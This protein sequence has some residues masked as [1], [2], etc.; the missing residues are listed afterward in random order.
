VSTRTALSAACAALCIVGCSDDGSDSPGPARTD[1][2]LVA[3]NGC[4]GLAEVIRENAIA[5]MN[6]SLDRAM[7]NYLNGGGCWE[8]DAAA[9]GDDGGDGDGSE[10]PGDVSETN[11]Q[12]AGVDEAD[13]VKTDGQYLYVTANGAL[14]ILAA[15]PAAATREVAKV[16]LEGDARKLFVLG[17]RALVYVSSAE[18]PYPC[19][20]GYDCDFGGDGTS[21]RLVVLDISDREKPV[22]LRELSL[23]GSLIAARRIGSAVHT[24]VSDGALTFEGLS[25]HPDD[26]DWCAESPS[27]L[28]VRARF[29]ELRK[30]NEQLIRA[31]DVLGRLPQVKDSLDGSSSLLASCQGFYATAVRQ[32]ASFTTLVSLDMSADAAPTLASVVSRPGAVYASGSA[33]YMAVRDNSYDDYWYY[34][35]EGGEA[36]QEQSAIHRF[37]IGERPELTVY[38]ASGTVPGHVINQFAMDEHADNLR[39]ATSIGWVPD[40]SAN[41]AVTVLARQGKDLVQLGQV[42]GIAPTEDIRSVRFDGERG[43]IVTFKKTDPLFVLDLAKPT[44]PRVL[45][46]LKI[47]GFSTY[48]HLMDAQHLLTIGYDAAD[49]GDFAYFTGILLQIFDVSDPES[50]RLAHKQVIGSR[51]SA[52]EAATNHLAFNY[53]AKKNLL[54]FPLHICEGGD[55]DGGY[56]TD[57]TFNGLMVYDV[58]A[59]G[60]FRERGRVAHPTASGE[61]ADEGCSQWWTS[62]GTDVKRSV[63]MDDFVYSIAN[64]VVRVQSLEALGSDV[65]SVDISG[66]ACEVGGASYADGA[67]WSDDDSCS[68]CSCQDGTP[69]CNDYC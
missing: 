34:G 41:S 12:V 32:G 64:D 67:R 5:E 30:K 59:E 22:K 39:V 58:T 69:V 33:L 31:T 11:N 37:R 20:Y 18:N 54:A 4:D 3:V 15:W 25:T 28:L 55:D 42:S 57:M 60:G 49:Q 66:A 35:D 62:A 24:V 8:E 27:E 52:S 1:A 29:A 2:A 45:S 63:I 16:D 40:P 68:E 19:S 53:F 48:M 38:E 17:D 7:H 44:A 61:Y 10:G 43:F 21:T 47:P 56:G 65:A 6:A 26:L 46:E 51:G 36:P 13:L 14:H 23:T 9:G 50:P